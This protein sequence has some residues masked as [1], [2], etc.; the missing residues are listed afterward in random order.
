MLWQEMEHKKTVDELYGSYRQYLTSFSNEF[1]LF[2]IRSLA[3]FI[4]SLLLTN[5]SQLQEQGFQ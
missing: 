4:N 1:I 3:N 2:V 5:S